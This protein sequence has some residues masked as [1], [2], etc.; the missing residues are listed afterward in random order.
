MSKYNV[1]IDFNLK[2]NI[3]EKGER[4]YCSEAYLCVVYFATESQLIGQRESGRLFM[5]FVFI[6]VIARSSICIGLLF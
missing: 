4:A 6:A 1:I 5:Y 2:F 3:S